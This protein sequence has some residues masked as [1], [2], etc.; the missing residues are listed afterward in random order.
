VEQLAVGVG[1]NEQPLASVRGSCVGCSN[2]APSRIEPQGGK[3]GEDVGKPK[4]KVSGHVLQD[5]PA[6]S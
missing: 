1:N 6:G 4:S 3:V 5:D 2:S